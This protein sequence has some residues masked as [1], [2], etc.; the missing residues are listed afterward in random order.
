MGLAAACTTLC[1]VLLGVA[2]DVKAGYLLRIHHTGTALPR[3]RPPWRTLSTNTLLAMSYVVI[4]T[5]AM[6]NGYAVHR[7][8]PSVQPAMAVVSTAVFLTGLETAVIKT[9]TL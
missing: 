8:P 4:R 6:A 2:E 7:R 9:M 3:A 5:A 1:G